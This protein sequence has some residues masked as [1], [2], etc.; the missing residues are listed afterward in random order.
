MTDAP[1]PRQIVSDPLIVAT[2]TVSLPT[3]VQA[4]IDARAAVA[5][6][7][8]GSRAWLAARREFDSAIFAV[9]GNHWH[10]MDALL[11]E[12]DRANPIFFEDD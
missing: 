1:P 9:P 10:Q 6:A 4:V 7:K 12:A 3:A 11:D 5:A 2:M 8:R